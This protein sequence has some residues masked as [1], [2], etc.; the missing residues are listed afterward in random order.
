MN[1]LAIDKENSFAKHLEIL[2]ADIPCDY[3]DVN[4]L[5]S[6]LNLDLG[7]KFRKSKSFQIES[8]SELNC[9]GT[10]PVL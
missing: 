8:K 5:N 1:A 9:N 7:K 2:I 10:F 4:I 3:P 6:V